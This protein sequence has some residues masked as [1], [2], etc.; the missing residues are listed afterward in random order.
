MLED[1]IS[2]INNREIALG[3]WLLIIFL[4]CLLSKSI[5]PS[6]IC[7]LQATFDIRMVS[8]AL[9]F[10]A[11]ISLIIW[12]LSCIQIWQTD[13]LF[14]TSMWFSFTGLSLVFRVFTIKENDN[15]FVSVFKDA[16]KIAIAFEFIHGN[17]LKIS[18]FTFDCGF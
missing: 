1:F 11:N 18:A 2:S 15:Y 6:L 8:L 5:R 10:A 13:Q 9:L 7:L 4:G 12:G 14:P 16:W 3:I 17:R